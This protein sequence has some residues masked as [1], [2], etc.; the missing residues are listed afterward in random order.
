MSCISSGLGVELKY[1][2]TRKSVR[3]MLEKLEK[4]LENGRVPVE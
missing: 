3:T 2:Y 4:Q 1:I